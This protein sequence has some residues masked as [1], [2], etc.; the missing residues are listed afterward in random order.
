MGRSGVS[1]TPSSKPAPTTPRVAKLGNKAGSLKSDA[2]TPSPVQNS[3]LSID[4]TSPRT[5]TS[6]PTITRRVSTPESEASGGFGGSKAG[7][8][9]SE[10]E[11][12]RAVELEQAGIEAAQKKEEDQKKELEAVRSQHALDMTALLTATEEL[13]KVKQ[14]LVMVTDTKNQALSHADDA[15]KIA[16]IHAEKADD[17]DSEDGIVAELKSELGSLRQ[18][19]ERAKNFEQEVVEKEKSYEKIVSDL[20]SELETLKEELDKS[21]TYE[22]DSLNKELEN[23]KEFEEKLAEEKA[24]SDQTVIQLKSEIDTLKQEL[25]KA[26]IL[27]E[28]LVEREKSNERSVKHFE[29]EMHSLQQ[30]LQVAKDFEEKLIYKEEAYEQLNVAESNR[31]ERSAS[32]SVESILKQLEG[33]SDKL[34]EAECEIAGLKE[35]VS[36]LEISLEKKKGDLEESEHQLVKAN[37]EAREALKNLES[38]RSELETVTEE[39]AQA[40]ENEKL[41]ASSVQDLLEE[42][43][44]LIN[45]LETLKEEE[46]K[47]KTAMES[48]ASALHEVSA[49]AREAKESLLSNSKQ[50]IDHL[51]S[52]VEQSKVDFDIQME[53][54]KIEESTL[55]HQNQKAEWEAKELELQNCIK[56]LEEEKST[57]Q[58]SGK[59]FQDTKAEW[60]QKELQLG[61]RR[62]NWFLTEEGLQLRSSLKEAMSETASLKEALGE[63]EAESLKLKDDLRA[64]ENELQNM[65]RENEQLRAAE[66]ATAWKIDELTKLLEE[67]KSFQKTQENGELSDSDKDYDLLPKVVEFSEENGYSGENKPQPE[68][69]LQQTEA[70]EK[71]SSTEMSNGVSV[72]A[73]LGVSAVPENANVDRDLSTEM[74]T[75]QGSLDDEVDSKTEPAE[76]FDQMNELPSDNGAN[77]DSKKKKK[78]LI[79]E[80]VTWAVFGCVGGGWWVVLMVADG[81]VKSN[82]VVTLPII[83]NFKGYMIMNNSNVDFTT[84]EDDSKMN[85]LIHDEVQALREMIQRIKALVGILYMS[86]SGMARKE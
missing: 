53:D 27:E 74:E 57:I 42:K 46:E 65:I 68:A 62:K 23:A 40:L 56:R 5:V 76:A 19:L 4:R 59:N 81:I 30:E 12:F 69:L 85:S 33:N 16:E 29:L 61:S 37:E 75:E 3:R 17:G 2:D 6:K 35:K 18:E 8:E 47:S 52:T 49:E 48:L 79:P 86:G 28:E 13:Q 25:E 67:A 78:T 7:R 73:Q 9:T 63:A 51:T 84:S 32:E 72:G 10:I 36:L 80:A 66:D 43:N 21:K 22:I 24:S 39:K 50:E 70:G 20:K 44:K 58:Q 60:E 45:D 83:N 34:H 77:S 11:K 1:D 38:L 31:L 26:K 55:E 64:K 54:L 71:Q 15:T 41:A 14:E 82:Q